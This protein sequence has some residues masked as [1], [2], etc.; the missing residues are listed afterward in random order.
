MAGSWQNLWDWIW[1]LFIDEW[2][3]QHVVVTVCLVH[4]CHSLRLVDRTTVT[5]VV[6][7]KSQRHTMQVSYYTDQQFAV[8]T[9]QHGHDAQQTHHDWKIRFLRR[10]SW[11]WWA[12][13]DPRTILETWRKQPDHH[14]TD[15]LRQQETELHMLHRV[16]QT[17]TKTVHVFEIPKRHN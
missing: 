3:L 7:N 5:A 14:W 2:K 12:S 4:I 8:V 6:V 9:D 1:V 15:F 10:C 11:C 16:T 17:T 13:S